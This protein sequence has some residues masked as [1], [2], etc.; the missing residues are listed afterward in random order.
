MFTHLSAAVMED[1][2]E[3]VHILADVLLTLLVDNPKAQTL[4]AIIMETSALPEV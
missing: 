1:K 2:L 4:A 3:R